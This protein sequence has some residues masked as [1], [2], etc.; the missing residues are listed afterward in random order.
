MTHVDWYDNFSLVDDGTLD[1]VIDYKG[2]E[3]RYSTEF[4]APYRDD[5][6]Y[7]N[8]GWFVRDQVQYD[9]DAI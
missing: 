2:T 1:T 7:L 9:I 5:R 6:G 4:T 3:Y 8:L